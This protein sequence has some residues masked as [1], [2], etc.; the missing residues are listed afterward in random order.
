[1][2]DHSV[3]SVHLVLCL[4]RALLVVDWWS[5]RT[6]HSWEEL[7]WVTASPWSQRFT[8]Q[9]QYMVSGWCAV[10]L[11]PLVNIVNGCILIIRTPCLGKNVPLYFW[12]TTLFFTTQFV[13]G[14]H[15][16]IGNMKW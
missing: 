15:S 9:V 2:N 5:K 8:E 6:G 1:V 12:H 11:K 10:L 14:R 7:V 3:I 4:M 13:L 16:I